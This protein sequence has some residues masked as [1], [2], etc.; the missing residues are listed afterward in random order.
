MKNSAPSVPDQ[1][2]AA[3][4]RLWRQIVAEYELD[5]PAG[6][7]ILTAGCE[8]FDRMKSAQ[9]EIKRDGLTVRDRFG[10]LKAHPACNVE[11]DSRA[12]LLQA[13]K[14]LN[15][16]VEPLKAIGRPHGS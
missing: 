10:Q 6:L 14:S 2:S 11:R 13:L 4:K 7:A 5:D 9:K 8:A 3:G 12:A 1:L 16:D 15:L